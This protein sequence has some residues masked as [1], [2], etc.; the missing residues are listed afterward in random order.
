MSSV[1][2]M[3]NKVLEV[4]SIPLQYTKCD[5]LRIGMNKTNAKNQNANL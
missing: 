3:L 5:Q 1:F 4:L 2:I